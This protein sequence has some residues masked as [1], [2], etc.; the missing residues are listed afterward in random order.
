[1]LLILLKEHNSYEVA[2]LYRSD[3]GVDGLTTGKAHGNNFN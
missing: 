3:H 1:M 2:A